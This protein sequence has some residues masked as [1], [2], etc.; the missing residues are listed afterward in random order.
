L[1]GRGLGEIFDE[2]VVGPSTAE[3]IE[4]SWLSKFTVYEPIAGGPDLSEARIRAGDF[5]I[6]DVRA[7]MGGVVIGA[8]VA[9]YKRI[10][11]GIRAIAFCT[12]RAHSE[13][14]AERFREH[15]VHALHV[16]GDTTAA[17]RRG[18][19]AALGN[20]GL[21]VICNANLFGEGVDVPTIGAAILLR[22]TASLTL[23]LQQVGRTLR[24][25]PGKE[26]AIV[27]DFAGN[28][29]R[30]GLPDEPRQWSLDSKPRRQ[31]QS[32]EGPRVRRCRECGAVNRVGGH[33]CAACGADLRTPRERAEIEMRLEETKRREAEDAIAR[34]SKYE[35]LAWAGADR[36]RLRLVARVARY[37]DGWVYFKLKEL[38]QP[39]ARA[40]G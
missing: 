12:D 5:A 15:G 29:A 4:S 17:V 32:H 26:K 20:G 30:H 37:K 21:E 27:L 34:M 6:E 3:L 38:A 23:Y 35:R 18:A 40:A 33:E 28:C 1:D 8:A 24:P 31:R 10:C 36:D 39:N 16:D 25:A 14:V 22:P 11:A 2:M 13:A 9:E 19:I 7:A